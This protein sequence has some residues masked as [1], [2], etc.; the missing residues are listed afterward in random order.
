MHIYDDDVY[1]IELQHG[2]GLQN[3]YPYGPAKTAK[4]QNEIKTANI[5]VKVRVIYIYISLNLQKNLDD[6]EFNI[7]NYEVNHI[8]MMMFT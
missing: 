5:S 6:T 8:Q 4:V 1:F 2:S 3:L 7:I